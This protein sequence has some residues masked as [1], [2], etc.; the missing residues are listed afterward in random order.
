MFIIRDSIQITHWLLSATL[1]GP[2]DKIIEDN[3]TAWCLAKIFR[4]V[5]SIELPENPEFK[6][7]F[8]LARALE[9][10]GYLHPET[11]EPKPYISVGNLR[12]ELSKLP[13]EI[14]LETCIDFLEHLLV[15]DPAKRPTAEMTL[16]HPFVHSVII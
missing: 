2:R 8:D 14:Y 11:G 13:Q 7:D 5:G 15:I 6:D 10:G 3:R 9:R 1:F 12:E 4:L 16:R